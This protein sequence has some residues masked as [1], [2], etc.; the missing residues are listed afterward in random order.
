MDIKFQ[1]VSFRGP[2]TFL[3]LHR[4]IS[5]TLRRNW[6]NKKWN[7]EYLVSLISPFLL[8]FWVRNYV[9]KW[10]KSSTQVFILR[11][12][13]LST[14][15]ENIRDHIPVTIFRAVSMFVSV[16]CFFQHPSLIQSDFQNST[17][18]VICG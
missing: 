5:P 17:L 15:T 8:F 4:N 1:H 9:R 6:E 2:Y 13:F 3:L 7:S 14:H 16:S 11:S 12:I 18:I 10:K